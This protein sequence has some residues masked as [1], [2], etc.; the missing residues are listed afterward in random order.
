MVIYDAKQA[1]FALLRSRFGSRAQV[2]WADPGRD[3]RRVSVWFG[4]TVE[5]T[6]EPTAM[7]AGRRKPSRLTAELTVRAVAVVPG[8]PQRAE[9]AVYGLRAEID[10]VV[11]D[12]FDPAT[13]PG[14]IDL[15]PVRATVTNG[16]TTAGSAAQID[17]VV[18]V[19]AHLMS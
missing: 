6:I 1:L 7:V 12:G 3:A 18:R 2:T 9:R 16:E 15:R 4:E 8:D 11:L 14:L 13:V 19:R 10:A 5:P 17:Y